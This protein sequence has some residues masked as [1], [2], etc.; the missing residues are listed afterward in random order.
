MTPSTL[1]SLIS[2]CSPC[3]TT[4]R[5]LVSPSQSRTLRRT[6]SIFPSKSTSLLPS[7]PLL[8]MKLPLLSIATIRSTAV[9]SGSWASCVWFS[10][11]SSAS[12]LVLWVLQLT[13]CQRTVARVTG[14]RRSVGSWSRTSQTSKL[15]AVKSLGKDSSPFCL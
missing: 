12:S 15:K 4:P 2:P 7:N 14:T 6:L 11:S 5:S 9:Q 10:F 3:P 13:S 1:M 8:P